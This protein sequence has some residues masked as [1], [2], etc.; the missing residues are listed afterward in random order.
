MVVYLIFLKHHVSTQYCFVHC[1]CHCLALPS[2]RG[3]QPLRSYNSWVRFDKISVCVCVCRGGGGVV[4]IIKTVNAA[5]K[6]PTGSVRTS[7][8]HVW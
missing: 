8:I 3:F 2:T 6:T 1:Y 7:Q 4:W 5:C